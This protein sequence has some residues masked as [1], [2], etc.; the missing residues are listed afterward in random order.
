[1]KRKAAFSVAGFVLGL[2]LFGKVP[3]FYVN[4]G[5]LTAIFFSAVDFVITRKKDALIFIVA[6]LLLFFGFSYMSIYQEKKT[7]TLVEFYECT[8]TV[9]ATVYEVTP[10]EKNT[11]LCVKSEKIGDKEIGVKFEIRIYGECPELKIGQRISLPVRLKEPNGIYNDGIFYY[12]DYQKSQGYFISGTADAEDIIIEGMSEESIRLLPSKIRA[13]LRREATNRLKEENAGLL[14]GILLGEKEGISEETKLQFQRSGISHL[15]AVSGLHVN[16]ILSFMMM[17]FFIVGNKRSSLRFFYIFGIL[18][19]IIITGASPSVV[20][21]GVMII[22]MELAWI[23][24][25]D[26]DPITSLFVAAFIILM[27][28]PFGIYDVGFQLSF[29]A[30]FGILIFASPAIEFLKVKKIKSKFIR[31]AINATIV[32]L[33]AQIA[34]LP[35]IMKSFHAVSILSVVTNV[36]VTPLV[37]TI[38]WSGIILMLCSLKIPFIAVVAAYICDTAL[39]VL[40]F[41]AEKISSIPFASIACPSLPALFV[42]SYI[43]FALFLWAVLVRK[44]K[45]YPEIFLGLA[46]ILLI[47]GGFLKYYDRNTVQVSYINVGQ[48]DSTL[49]QSGESI[50][51]LIDG[52]GSVFSDVGEYILDDFLYDRGIVKLS[53]A[54]ITHFDIDHMDGIKTLLQK[55]R[56]GM[57]IVPNVEDES[58]KEI[59]ELAKEQ[60]VPI[61]KISKNDRIYFSDRLYFDCLSP[62]PKEEFKENDDAGAAL[63]LY[64]NGKSFFFGGDMSEEREGEVV[65]SFPNL[66]V[67]VLK[68]NHH[69]SKYSNSFLFLSCL[70]PEFVVIS[71]GD[72]SY[73]HPSVEAITRFRDVGAKLFETKKQG[74]ITFRVTDNGKMYYRTS[75]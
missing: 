29:M 28:N 45:F 71:Y 43:M 42:L 73:G 13:Y 4:I 61:K 65:V 26:A 38:L 37:P 9:S 66:D 14:I 60:G 5:V 48:G 68:A 19:V 59:I 58:G 32:T 10:K 70:S 50:S 72:N 22:L 17:L 57:L 62:I 31:G 40:R 67:D 24:K 23:F 63:V 16:L 12:P 3:A 41:I 18:A 25:R 20:R 55:G 15:T 33:S 56:V 51:V 64:A 75:R 34:I 27:K 11:T 8:E 74:T 49:I 7:E 30:T 1:M 53:A 52:G 69:G 6:A 39:T 46:V 54:V 36:L 35:L 44:A 21:A 2:L 47:S